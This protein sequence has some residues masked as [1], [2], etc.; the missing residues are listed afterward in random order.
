MEKAAGAAT[1]HVSRSL[2]FLHL[3][4]FYPP[5]SF[6]GDGIY[7][8][9]LCHALADAGHAVDV[10]HCVDSYHLLHPAPPTIEFAEH[11]G[12]T[13]H[14]LRSP[15]GRLS[16]VL[17][18][19]SGRPY[20]KRDAIRRLLSAKPYDVIHFH[21]VSLFGPQILTLVPRGR[22]V[23]V[24]TLHEHWLICPTHVLWKYNRRPCEKPDCLRCTV[25]AKRPPQ[26][27]RYTGLL[28]SCARY[29][30]LFLPPSRF[31][32]DMH[33]S[34]GFSAA[35]FEILPT[36]HP[37]ADEH[38]PR[39]A[40]PPHDRPYFLF[41][42][43]LETVNGLHTLIPLWSHVPDCD[44]LVAGTGSEEQRL[45]AL[46]ASNPHIRFLGSLPQQQLRSLY[47]QAIA[48]IVP[49]VTA[50]VFPMVP[51]EALAC[52]TP[53]IARDLGGLPES[54]QGGGGFLYRT[55]EELLE[56]IT[57][58]KS[59]PALRAELGEK[60]H[61]AYRERWTPEA[62]LSQY[63]HLL[64]QTALCKFGCVPWDEDAAGD[65]LA[66]HPDSDTGHG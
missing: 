29:V 8:H 32:A 18:Y 6:G 55:D 2:N 52:G 56:A 45:R 38:R 39:L 19:L 31:T 65:P 42:G 49:S 46:A 10:V 3:T 58:L 40:S 64:R 23:K 9:R 20:L 60:G 4:T 30:D 47:V 12:V 37:L 24:Y 57:L 28:E 62:H 35:P 21:N 27:W 1:R 63:F 41:V 50:E 51:V 53:V 25:L 33:A 16:P 59:S 15:L 66:R 17:T 14:E 43:R 5:Y 36:F 54:L 34:R 48:C 11:P 7:V 26:L 13:R 61:R 22:A 44:L